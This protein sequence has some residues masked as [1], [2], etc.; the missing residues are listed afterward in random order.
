MSKKS[1]ST[2]DQTSHT[3][4][5]P[6]NPDWITQPVM[7]LA[8]RINDLS[9]LDPQ[10]LVAGPNALQTQAAQTA[11]ALGLPAGYSHAGD[12][13]SQV[14][15]SGPYTYQPT[16]GQAV[17]GNAVT[18]QAATGTA[19][20]LLDNLQSYFS[21]YQS[22]VVNSALRD[23]DFGAGQTRAQNALALANDD[24][25]GGSG[26]AIQTALSEDA[27][28]RGRGTLS[29]QLLNQGFQSAANLSNL[30]ADRRQAMTLANLGATNQFGLANLS[31]Q[32][33]Y[34]LANLGAQNQ[35]GLANAQASNDASRFNAQQYETM[36][37]RQLAAGTAMAN[38]AAQQSNDARANVA[39]QAAIGD[40]LRQIAAAQAVAPIS[41]L[42]SQTGL[43][44]ALP[45]SLFRGET[46]DGNSTAVTT[47]KTSDPL[48]TIAGVLSLPIGSGTLG[49]KIPF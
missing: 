21:P 44:N 48:G 40:M 47:T 12:I 32:N 35:F 42:T 11:A 27:I 36:L 45:L 1:K 16:F 31:A 4:V 30:D 13:F 15:G 6:T 23:Y 28:D 22:S 5:T 43:L 33:Q 37:Q 18:G 7:N 41:L 14:A 20:S 25:F 29:S 26:G 9:S 10:S 38:S 8:G 3:V 46:Q 49:S 24:T 2:T 34:G 39:S 19:S 17:T